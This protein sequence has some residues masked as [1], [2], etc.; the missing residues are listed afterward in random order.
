MR[1]ATPILRQQSLS[2]PRHHRGRSA[3]IPFRAAAILIPLLAIT[4]SG[5]QAAL[6]Q[7]SAG[8]LFP[9]PFLIEHSVIITEPDGG[10]FMSDPVVDHYG[11]STIVSERADGSRLIVDFA[12]RELTE[13]RPS[14]G[15]YTVITFDRMAQ[16]TREYQRLEGPPSQK[17]ADGEET[18][19]ITFSVNEGGPA[20]ATKIASA[21]ALTT[22]AP[23]LEKP[24]IRRLEITTQRDG[25]ASPEPALEAWM[26]PNHRLTQ[27]A[28]DAV[29]DFELQVLGATADEAGLTPLKALAAARRHARG[30]MPIATAR[31]TQRGGGR[32][33]DVAVRIESLDAFPVDL[34]S[35]PEGL[36]RSPH[37]LE[38]M[39]AHAEREAEL[40]RLMGGEVE[41]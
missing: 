16:L 34:V 2:I 30:A 12:R 1:T 29:E 7:Q 3:M 8:G 28:L 35:I 10:S 36:Q 26:D 9:S 33:E 23:L 11:G 17:A 15:T 5:E 24:G 18:P 6:A 19:E 22:A 32:V 25:E 4:F 14:S 37:P 40:R 38:L 41:Q 21:A 13:I 31:L 39:V 20:G 27:R